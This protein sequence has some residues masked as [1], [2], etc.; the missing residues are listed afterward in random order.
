[1]TGHGGVIFILTELSTLRGWLI[2]RVDSLPAPVLIGA[3][4]CNA[5]F[6]CIVAKKLP[7]RAGQCRTFVNITDVDNS[8]ESSG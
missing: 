4:E 8:V 2:H 3:A 7:P 5:R 6:L 1:M